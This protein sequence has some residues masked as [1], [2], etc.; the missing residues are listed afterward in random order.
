MREQKVKEKKVVIE[1]G[2]STVFFFC[3]NEIIF[4]T[5]LLLL[6]LLLLFFVYRDRLCVR[7]SGMVFESTYQVGETDRRAS[8][9]V[10]LKVEQFEQGIYTRIT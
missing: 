1:A 6:L 10:E 9:F 5:W 8:S 2:V 4:F 7:A 3:F